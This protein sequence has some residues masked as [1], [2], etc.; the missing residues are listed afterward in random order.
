MSII[1]DIGLRQRNAL[2]RAQW[3]YRYAMGLRYP[4]L[5]TDDERWWFDC[6]RTEAYMRLL[7]F[8]KQRRE[9][10]QRPCNVVWLRT[11]K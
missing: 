11:W 8:L 4:D 1:R 2:N 6:H 9:I 7:R 10:M 3:T 5:R